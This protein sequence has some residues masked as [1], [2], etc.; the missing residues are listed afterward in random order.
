MAP[1]LLP[2]VPDGSELARWADEGIRRAPSHSN[3]VHFGSP[4]ERY[5]LTISMDDPVHGYLVELY[6]TA[7]DDDTPIGRTIVDD[8]DLALEVAAHMAAAADDLDAL[9]DRPHLGP[10]TVYLEDIERDELAPETPAEWDDS[11]AWEDAL[12]EAFEKAEI[13]RS[14]GTL[15]TKTIDGRDYYYLQWREGDSVKSQY[16]APVS[17]S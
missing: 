2:P 13:P 3:F 14:K 17:P 16:V 6:A 9:V 8:R 7:R 11:E 12:A 4:D 10:D 15:T 5:S 1:S